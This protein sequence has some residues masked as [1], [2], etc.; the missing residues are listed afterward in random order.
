MV[1]SMIAHT[2]LLESLESEALKTIVYFL[3][4]VP[5]KIV[6]KNPYKLWSEKSLSIRHLHIWGCPAETRP[7]IPYEKKLDSRTVSCFFVGY[8]ERFR[9]FRF[10][11][12]ST[13]N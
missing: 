1:R 3:N 10:Y 7:Y 8:F 4:R 9:G 12:P 2:T 11:C 13:K 5:S 6:T